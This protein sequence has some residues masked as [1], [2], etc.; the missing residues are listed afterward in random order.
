M[1]CPRRT[2]LDALLVGA[3]RE[4]GAEVREDTVVRDLVFDD[5]RVTGIRATG[6]DGGTWEAH[7]T[8]TVGADGVFSRVAGAPSEQRWRRFIRR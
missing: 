3:A 2:V 7:A 5:G 4:A 6:P 1:F 8:V